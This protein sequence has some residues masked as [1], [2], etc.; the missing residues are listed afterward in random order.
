[1]ELEVDRWIGTASAEMRVLYHCTV[2]RAEPEAKALN[3]PVGLC[4][5]PHPQS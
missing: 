3:L 2:V 4:F 5:N 1:M